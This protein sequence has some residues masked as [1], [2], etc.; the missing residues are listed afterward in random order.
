MFINLSFYEALL[1]FYQPINPSIQL[2]VVLSIFSFIFLSSIYLSIYEPICPSI[3]LYLPI[4]PF[5][6]SIYLSPPPWWLYFPL[7]HLL[8]HLGFFSSCFQL[9]A[10]LGQLASQ[11][12]HKCLSIYLSIFISIYLFIFIYLSILSTKGSYA[13]HK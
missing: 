6:S 3:Y 5:Y 8:I 2:S 4:Y 10:S 11:Q 9:F 1:S 12:E 13:K 7:R